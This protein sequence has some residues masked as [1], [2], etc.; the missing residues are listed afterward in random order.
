VLTS[1]ATAAARRSGFTVRYQ[2]PVAA[3]EFPESESAASVSP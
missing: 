1:A 2:V 3:F